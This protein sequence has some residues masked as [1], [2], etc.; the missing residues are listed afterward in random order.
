MPTAV[1][2]PELELSEGAARASRT[3]LTGILIGLLLPAILIALVIF[4][5]FMA[6]GDGLLTPIMR[7]V[8]LGYYQ[9]LDFIDLG[10]LREQIYPH[11][12]GYFGPIGF[13]RGT[14]PDSCFTPCDEAVGAFC[15]DGMEC[16]SG[17]CSSDAC[18]TGT[19]S[20]VTCGGICDAD[21]GYDS[22]FQCAFGLECVEGACVD[23]AI[24]GS[25]DI[26]DGGACAAECSPM[27]QCLTSQGGVCGV[28][29]I[30][31]SPTG[32]WSS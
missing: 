20:R 24:C 5:P 1:E 7:P 9:F 16:T 23:D 32:F 29:C 3:N 14:A 2:R 31:D 25:I 22:P 30:K 21:A 26:P 17:I 28:Y 19:G 8:A 6:Q 15:P 18:Y 4:S 11:L 13:D 27:A 10:D 12:P